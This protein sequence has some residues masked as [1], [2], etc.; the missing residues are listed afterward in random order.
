MKRIAKTLVAMAA[1]AGSSASALTVG[2]PAPD[3]K[4]AS[5]SGAEVSLKDFSGSWLVLYFYPKSFTPGCTKEACSLRDGFAGILGLGAKILGVSVDSLATQQKFKA[6]H[7]LPFDLLADEDKGVA[8]AYDALGLG[9]LMARRVT[10][11]IS[12]DGRIARVIDSVRTGDHDAQVAESLREL[13]AGRVE[14]APRQ[15]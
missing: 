14:G 3:F 12:P 15:P 8:R 1:A 5:T 9:G 13:Q 2:D 6:E 7:Q 11:L 4:A 10:Y